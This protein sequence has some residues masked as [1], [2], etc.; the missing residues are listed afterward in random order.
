ML[1]ATALRQRLLLRPRRQGGGPGRGPAE[2]RHG[3]GQLRLLVPAGPANPHG[4]HG[5]H[6]YADP[7]PAFQR[8]GVQGVC[9][10]EVG[11][12]V[13]RGGQMRK[14]GA[15]GSHVTRL[16]VTDSHI[17]R[18]VVQHTVFLNLFPIFRA[19]RWTEA[20]PTPRLAAVRPCLM[21]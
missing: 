7:L 15:E 10:A 19:G 1:R 13:G 14:R 9:E 5:P 17:Y 12:A 18:A 20:P 11:D 3:E 4:R 21:P 16:L 8:R 6:R 2:G